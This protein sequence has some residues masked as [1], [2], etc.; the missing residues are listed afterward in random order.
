MH[1]GTRYCDF[2]PERSITGPVLFQGQ[3]SGLAP[4]TLFSEEIWPLRLGG[5]EGTSLDARSLVPVAPNTKDDES[6]SVFR[7]RV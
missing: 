2:Y 3:S 7:L 1:T 6:D 5:N 4:Q